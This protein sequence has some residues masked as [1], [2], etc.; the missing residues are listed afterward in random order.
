MDVIII[1][2][3][4]GGLCCGAL[5]AHY[6][7]R[8]LICESHG[9]P[10]G[11]AHSFERDGFYFDSGPSL[12]S[13]LSHRSLNPLRQVLD[14]IGEA[15][16]IDWIPYDAW[17]CYVPEGYFR[18]EVGDQ[19]FCQLLQQWRGTEAVR[20]WQAL[21]A[22]LE[23]LKA[24]SV[25]IPP[26]ALRSDWGSVWTVGRF[27]PQML[28]QIG[29]LQQLSGSFAEV[30]EGV[31][32]DPF[33]R[34][35]MDLLCFMLSGLPAQGT[36]AAEMAFMFADWYRPNVVLDYPR[37]GSDALVKALIRGLR[38][39][40]GQLRLGATVE[41]IVVERDRAVGVKLRGGEVLRANQAIVSN[42]SI[43]NTLGLL[44]ADKIPAKLQERQQIQACPS[45]MH[46]HLGFDAQGVEANLPE[47]L[48]E[49]LECHYLVVNDWQKG[50]DAPQNVVAV[51]IPS[52]LDPALAPPNH[53]AL[54]AYLPATEPYELWANLDRSSDA[55]RTLKAERSQIFWQALERIIPDLRQRCRVTL[56]GTPLT[57]ERF[58]RRHQG[59]Y[60]PAIAA[61][62]GLFPGYPTHLKGLWCCGDS[63]FPGI[64]VPAVAASG[65]ATAHSLVP[66]A[67][68]LDSIKR[69]LS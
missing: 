38:K 49:K 41:E 4:L 61:G 27:L 60:G 33:I 34:N 45:F 55:Y 13:G 14:I 29:N 18:A 8:V 22:K 17:G 48:A 46:L 53:H 26:L 36:I 43:W 3:G 59:T 32:T 67:K 42:A 7:V 51:S 12:Y 63:T 9:I 24:A 50:V 2:S 15:D 37:G 21:Q 56:V 52:V 44:P 16:S 31:I 10:G 28:P 30:M 25:A 40:G 35:W 69:M 39:N 5:L 11:A 6:G 58:L 20:E 62:A 68:Q 57:H 65:M 66:V 19:P 23:P 64:G 47:A 54:H 1:G